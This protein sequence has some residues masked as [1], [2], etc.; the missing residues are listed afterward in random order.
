M[1]TIL[2]Q[3]TQ[4]VVHEAIKINI[5]PIGIICFISVSAIILVPI[6]WRNIKQ[7]LTRKKTLVSPDKQKNS[8]CPF[9]GGVGSVDANL[10]AV[11]DD[12]IVT[13]S[14]NLP[15]TCSVREKWDRLVK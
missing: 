3:T 10:Y 5:P 1:I 11:D 7:R 15:C 6:I 14:S 4:P 13:H 2:L 8:D 9:C 12:R